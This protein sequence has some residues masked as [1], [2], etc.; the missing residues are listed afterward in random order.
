MK[1]VKKKNNNN[2]PYYAVKPYIFF[3]ETIFQDSLTIR[4]FKAF[5]QIRN[6][7]YFL[8]FFQ[9]NAS[10]VNKVFVSLKIIPNSKLLNDCS[11]TDLY[12]LYH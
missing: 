10:L 11:S 4:K 12:K 1:K 3:M 5:S 2:A 7:F 8:I 6:L 9:L